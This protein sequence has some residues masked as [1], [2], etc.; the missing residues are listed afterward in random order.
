MLASCRKLSALRVQDKL[1]SGALPPAKL[2]TQPP[3]G[4][5][6]DQRARATCSSP[7]AGTAQLPRPHVQETWIHESAA[8]SADPVGGVLAFAFRRRWAEAAVGDSQPLRRRCSTQSLGALAL[9]APDG[10]RP[11]GNR[12]VRP[13]AAS[14]TARARHRRSCSR[15]PSGEPTR[16][17]VI[18]VATQRL[19][20]RRPKLRGRLREP[21][22][23][24]IGPSRSCQTRTWPSVPAPAPIPIVGTAS[25]AAP[26]TIARAGLS[27]CVEADP[28]VTDG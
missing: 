4:K 25:L 14:G 3:E 19:G 15:V 23:P 17:D 27:P 18:A 12:R 22:P 21:R 24:L 9:P 28:P 16:A 10:V 11:G 1:S 13:R 2:E 26:L 7:G 8:A 5:P 6:L 20:D